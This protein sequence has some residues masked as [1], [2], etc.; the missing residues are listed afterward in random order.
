MIDYV[1][2]KIT[3]ITQKSI[4]VEAG[5]VGFFVTVPNSAAFAVG[6]SIRLCVY[7]HWNQE[8]GPTLYGFMHEAERVVFLLITS[9][10]GVGPK[11]GM[12]TL[13]VLSPQQFLHA[14][15]AENPDALSQVPGIGTKKAEQIIVQLKHKVADMLVEFADNK[16]VGIDGID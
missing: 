7:L 5:P 2:G 13:S 6:S 10:S 9:C 12:A 3:H 16:T 15:Q 14:V 11:I 4:T 8:Q 1:V